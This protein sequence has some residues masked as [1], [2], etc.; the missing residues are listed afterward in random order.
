[1]SAQHSTH[2]ARRGSALLMVFWAVVVMSVCVLGLARY[3]YSNLDETIALKKDSRVQQLAESGIAVALN[4][5]V[6]RG[7]SVLRQSIGPGGSF[8]V[9]LRSEGGRL[10]INT[11]I[12]GGEWSVLG[13]LLGEWGMEGS[14]VD[15]LL[16][17]FKKRAYPGQAAGDAAAATAVAGT[18]PPV[19]NANL[20]QSVD[21]M[22]AVPGMNT[23]AEL[24]P[25]WRDYFTVWSDGPLD[26]NDAPA[27]LIAAVSGVGMGRAEQLVR[28]R[29]GPDGK[30]DTDDDLVFTD[31]EQVRVQLGM[32]QEQFST[33]QGQLSVQDS[34]ARIES[35][36]ILGTTRRTIKAVVRRSV[37][38][39]VFF[40]WQES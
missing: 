4:P 2:T 25:D 21:E 38:P 28:A 6:S 10:N 27:D 12:Q 20:F 35:T 30:P 26:V 36:G 34:A 16:A 39:P 8:E 11:V 22:L 15:N 24:K 5:L 37:S 18:Q 33:I 19:Q 9:R 13:T 3:L 29:L 7:D 1:M 23:V 32:S 17:A 40:Q 14:D 31:L